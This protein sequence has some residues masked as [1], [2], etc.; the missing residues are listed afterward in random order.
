MVHYVCM[1]AIAG[2][3]GRKAS[4]VFDEL[5]AQRNDDAAKRLLSELTATIDRAELHATMKHHKMA[6]VKGGAQ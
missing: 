3:I 4:K 5:F 2:V 6:A 1:N